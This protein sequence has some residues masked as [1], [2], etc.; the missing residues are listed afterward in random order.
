ML[1]GYKICYLG[2]IK[3]M[4][5]KCIRWVLISYLGFIKIMGVYC[6][7]IVHSILPW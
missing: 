6:V 2:G 4:G 5:A 7:G 1:I 3:I